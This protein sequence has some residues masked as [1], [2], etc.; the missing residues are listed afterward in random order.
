MLF[1]TI[2][3]RHDHPELLEALI[4]NSSVPRERVILVATA[5]NLEL[6]TGCIVIN[7]F[8]PPNI[9]RWWLTGIEEAIRRGA[10]AVA[11]LNDDLRINEATLPTLYTSLMETRASVATPTRP[12]W[13]PGLYKS[14]NMH[15]YTPVIWGCLWM[16]NTS[17]ELRPNPKYVWWYGD[18][19]LDIRARR[20]LEGIVSEDVFYEH[21]SPGV[22]TGNSNELTVQ[23]DLDAI[24]FENE[25]K[26]FLKQSRS[27]SP[28]KLFIQLEQFGGSKNANDEYRRNFYKYV[29]SSADNSRDRIVLVE[30]N[31]DLHASLF[32]LW[33]GWSNVLVLSTFVNSS[34]IPSQ[35]VQTCLMYRVNTQEYGSRQSLYK[36]D[37]NR[38]NPNA[39]VT[40]VNTPT[41]SFEDLIEDVIHG[42]TLELIAFDAQQHSLALLTRIGKR[43]R[44]FVAACDPDTE[45]ILRR[46]ALSFGLHFSGRPWG[47]AHTSV[48]FRYSQSPFSRLIRTNF[49]H[50]ISSIIDRK[51][52]LATSDIIADFLN[53]NMRSKGTRSDILDSRHGQPLSSVS[54]T[55]VNEVIQRASN[56]QNVPREDDFQWDLAID[57]E[58]QVRDQVHACHESHGVWPLSLSIPTYRELNQNPSE[59]VSPIIPGY[60][61]SFTN[62]LAYLDKYAESYFAVTHRK[63]GWDCFR[64]VEIMASGSVPLMPDA[65]EIPP[66]SMVHYPKQ[67]LRAIFDQ[68]M[69]E[70]GIPSLKARLKLRD[71]FLQHL[72]TQKMGAY[73]LQVSGVPLDASVLFLDEHLTENPDYISTLTA[74]GLKENMGKN[75]VLFHSSDFLYGDSMRNTS[76]FY[77]RG[78]GYCKKLNPVFRSDWEREAK[79]DPSIKDLKLKQF[80][81]VVIGS[82]TRNEALTHYVLENF[83][84]QNTILIHG[85]D[86][87][88]TLRES[89]LL[90]STNAQIFVRSIY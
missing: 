12:D 37:V 90:K 83:P 49:G 47:E 38:L 52:T 6:P 13:G 14:E 8:D 50:L 32:E 20:D 7:D 25:Y 2:P 59:L 9:Q 36:L 41:I 21:V 17:T 60:P 22:G 84:G 23:T 63:A 74:I 87:P 76:H 48:A 61:Y 43:P 67:A 81:F 3:T 72:T 64:H 68:V 58:E 89:K 56:T 42:C 16:V 77:G 82:V 62:E 1:L 5:P 29:Q 46:D 75:C 70:G 10:S 27:T 31:R 66:F 80:D 85:E 73:L 55:A 51:K 40:E 78:F 30:P 19:D 79:K 53:V 34:T 26:D 39:D 4:E 24:T 44:E 86:S 35:Q 88:P 69:F 15:P 11:V 28:R 18:S 71:F 57:T 54:V 65:K 33:N 45:K